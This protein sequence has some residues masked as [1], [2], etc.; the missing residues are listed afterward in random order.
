MNT[1]GVDF[2]ETDLALTIPF[3]L[4]IALGAIKGYVDELKFG[5]NSLT[6]TNST[7]EDVWEGG[8]NYTGQPEG[9]TPE[10]VTAVSDDATD[11]AAGTGARTIRIHGLR[12]NT[13]EEVETEDMTLNGTTLV[14]SV[15]TWYRVN[16]VEVLTAGSGGENAGVITIAAQV[17]TANIFAAVPVD[18]NQSQILAFTVPFNRT[19]VIRRVRIAITR[20]SGADGSANITIRARESGG[21]YRAIRNFELQTGAPVEFTALG[22]IVLPALTDVKVRIESVSDNSTITEGALEY[23]LLSP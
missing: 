22:G 8:G 4:E 12:S 10:L 2:N 20:A 5:R 9:F 17:T 14:N 1:I 21:V 15:N 7:P 13:S 16:R 23:L 11:T 3:E 18:K 6:N 19:C